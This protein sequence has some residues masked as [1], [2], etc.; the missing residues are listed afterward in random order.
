MARQAFV[1]DHAGEREARPLRGVVKVD[2]DDAGP[3]TVQRRRL[4]EGRRGAG[5][6]LRRYAA[7]FEGVGRHAVEHRRQLRLDR[8]ELMIAERDGLRLARVG[9]G[10]DLRRV[11]VERRDALAHRALCHA[12]LFQDAVD[13][14]GDFLALIDAHLV[15]FGCR[16]VGRGREVQGGGVI[17]FAILDFPHAGIR[18][19]VRAQRF[20]FGDLPVEGR[21][22]FVAVDFRRAR[23]I[24]VGKSFLLR[25]PRDGG[26]EQRLGGRHAQRGQLFQRA[27]QNEV[28]RLDVH[29]LIVLHPV[30]VVVDLHGEGF[31]AREIGIGVRRV[32]DAVLGVEEVRHLL[33]DAGELTHG[34]G[35]RPE[36]RSAEIERGHARAALAHIDQRVVI[37]TVHAGKRVGVQRFQPRKLALVQRLV[38]GDPRRGFIGELAL[39]IRVRALV[40]TQDR[41]LFG[42]LAQVLL[43]EGVHQ[44]VEF[45]GGRIGRG[46]EGD[47]RQRESGGGGGRGGEKLAAVE[48]GFPLWFCR[49]ED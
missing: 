35:R 47:L 29:A 3:R 12:L 24:G 10:V 37:H 16:H 44:A 42:T 28:R 9:V 31:E 11:L 40:E 45:R 18:R 19:G 14:V 41:R 26:D 46:C 48:H 7:H 6:G 43:E 25:A 1:E 30:G 20:R 36:R 39:Q 49:A 38:R 13:A 27:V 34:I 5:F 21:C 22:D 2:I 15:D 17:G 23:R 8:I 4:A 32:F 33:I